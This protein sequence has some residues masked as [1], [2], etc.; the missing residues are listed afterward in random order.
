MNIPFNTFLGPS[1]LTHDRPVN[2]RFKAF[3]VSGK[4]L[5]SQPFTPPVEFTKGDDTLVLLD[6]S[7]GK[8]ATLPDL[9]AHA[10][11]GTIRGGTCC[12]SQSA[13]PQLALFILH[14]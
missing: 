7:A 1:A 9:S 2:C 13:Q 14:C 3:R 6:F 4:Q 12:S 5:Y 10:P 8:G 11:H